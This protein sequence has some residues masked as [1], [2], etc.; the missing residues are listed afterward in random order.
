VSVFASP[1]T[2]A[3]RDQ[4]VERLNDVTPGAG[5][6]IGVMQGVFGNEDTL[7][8]GREE[9]FAKKLESLRAGGCNVYVLVG[10][11]ST[12]AVT[13]APRIKT[14]L[15]DSTN[16]VAGVRSHPKIHDK[17]LTIMG[18]VNGTQKQIVFTGSHNMTQNALDTNDEMIVR[19]GD[20]NGTTAGP[21]FNRYWEGHFAA[22]FN[23]TTADDICS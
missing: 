11:D 10:R 22:Q 4:W 20:S 21:I 5:C 8:G 9:V 16:R 15:C 3:G 6:W 1:E 12:G 14:I 17:G 18:L 23:D 19:V 13:I 2:T 7:V